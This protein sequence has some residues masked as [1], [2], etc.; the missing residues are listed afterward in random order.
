MAPLRCTRS[1]F[2][3]PSTMCS[4][5]LKHIV[6]ETI[7][8]I[9]KNLGHLN[10]GFLGKCNANGILGDCRWMAKNLGLHSQIGFSNHCI[11]VLHVVKCKLPEISYFA[12]QQPSSFLEVYINSNNISGSGQAQSKHT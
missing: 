12:G 7:S 3:S 2:S 10:I 11:T 5:T 1:F 4:S 6:F 8:Q 9:C